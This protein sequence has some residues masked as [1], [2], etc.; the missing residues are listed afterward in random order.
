MRLSC[1]EQMLGNRSFPEKLAIIRNEGF[2]GVDGRYETLAD[3]AN[4]RALRQSGLPVGAMYSQIRAPGLLS[5]TAAERAEALEVMV[6]R[7]TLAAAVGARCMVVVPIF[8]PPKVRGFDPVMGTRQVE[9]ALALTMLTAVAER[10]ADIPITV[11]LEPLNGDETHFL[12]DPAEAARWCAA[13]GSPRVATMVDTYHCAKNG[14]EIPATIVA[15]GNQLALVHLSDDE[16][17]LPGDGQ[18][19]FGPILA[20]LQARGY[21]GWMGFECKPNT[22]TEE[23]LGRSVRYLRDLWERNEGATA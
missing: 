23:G 21:D 22:V 8:G 18:L 4:R 11:T 19:D 10:L 12:T 1:A 14:Q 16:R 7:A 15:V 20:A 5:R 6:L 13:I 3:P 17:Q 9:T 2:D